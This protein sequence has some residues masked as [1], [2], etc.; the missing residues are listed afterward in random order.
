MQ[1]VLDALPK[2][3]LLAEIDEMRPQMQR[4][5]RRMREV[6]L[7][8]EALDYSAEMEAAIVRAAAAVPGEA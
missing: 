2:E 3:K 6:P 4:R 7:V 5:A 8:D 1:Q